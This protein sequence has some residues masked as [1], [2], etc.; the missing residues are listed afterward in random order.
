ML[1]C[2]GRVFGH[3][4]YRSDW[5]LV[6]VDFRQSF[7]RQ[8]AESDYESWQL[9]DLQV[10]SVWNTHIT[11]ICTFFYLYSFHFIISSIRRGRNASWVRSEG[12]GRGRT[13]RSASK[14]K[15]SRRL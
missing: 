1:V 3:I 14:G 5:E 9:M 8:C 4:S 15:A 7:P 12:S 2:V 6:K 13:R 11:Q 10:I